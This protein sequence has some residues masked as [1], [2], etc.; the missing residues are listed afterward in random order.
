MKTKNKA[1]QFIRAFDGFKVLRLSYKQGRDQTRRFSMYIFLP[2]A[3]DGLSTLIQNLASESGFLEQTFPRRKLPVG[4]FMIPKFKISYSVKAADVLKELGVVSPFSPQDADFSKMLEASGKLHVET[5]FHKAFI[6]VNEQGTEAAAAT[7]VRGA[8][9]CRSQIPA[10]IDFVANHPF[11]F[12]IREDF[13][14]TVLFIGQVLNPLDGA[15]PPSYMDDDKP[16]VP[17]KRK[18]SSKI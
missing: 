7:L 15:D 9:M 10:G 4:H 12:L 1:E 11:L 14:G 3:K 13:T 5:I 16:V 18:M 17:K 8:R 6:E 2:D